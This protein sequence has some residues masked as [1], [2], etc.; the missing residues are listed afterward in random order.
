M[1]N[2][3]V[4]IAEHVDDHIKPVTYE[5][6][7][8]AKKLQRSTQLNSVKVLLLAEEVQISAHELAEKS[9]LDVIAIQIPELTI[10]NGERYLQVLL[11]FLPD[12][13][14]AFVCIAH[15]TQGL[16]Y[17]PALAVKLN[18][19]C[20][21][22]VSDV[23]NHAGDVSFTKPIY[24][25]KITARLQPAS[26]IS[27][28]TIQPGVFKA[29]GVAQGS[30]G[31]ITVLTTSTKNCHSRSLGIKQS[32]TDTAGISDASVIVAAGMGIGEKENLDFIQDS[33]IVNLVQLT[34]TLW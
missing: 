31:N 2:N 30:D 20:V 12:M 29:D 6:I 18:A 28:L 10:Y 17:A 1:G 33:L 25:G 27:V 4:V 15:T 26:H 3:I 16:D 23:L 24:G 21:T 19:A 7:S 9:G 34:F 5:I 14:P 11:E 8:F 22:G 32:G 13:Q